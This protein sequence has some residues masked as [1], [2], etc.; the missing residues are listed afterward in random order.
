M[1]IEIKSHALVFPFV[2]KMSNIFRRSE[3]LWLPGAQVSEENSE[4]EGIRHGRAKLRQVLF[5]LD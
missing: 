5:R 4:G 3:M 2:E 1:S